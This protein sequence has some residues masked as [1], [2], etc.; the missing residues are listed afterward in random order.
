MQARYSFPRIKAWDDAITA[1]EQSISIS[2]SIEFAYKALG[3]SYLKQYYR[4]ESL[5]D[6]P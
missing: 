4:D 2:A 5:V 1:L 3:H 6:A